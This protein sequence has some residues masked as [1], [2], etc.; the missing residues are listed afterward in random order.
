D[1][2]GRW[3]GPSAGAD[4]KLPVFLRKINRSDI[5]KEERRSGRK[6]DVYVIQRNRGPNSG[7]RRV[8][9]DG[10]GPDHRINW[11]REARN[12]GAKTARGKV[13]RFRDRVSA[14]SLRNFR[15][16]CKRADCCKQRKR[17][18]CRTPLNRPPQRR[19]SSA[20]VDVTATQ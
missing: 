15:A 16:Q 9:C 6:C 19:R 13:D 12:E 3:K 5:A 1:N 11:N 10:E 17:F 4:K 7:Y 20:A 14:R 2:G 18:H 8:Y